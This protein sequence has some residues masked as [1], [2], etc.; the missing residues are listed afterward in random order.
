MRC[1]DSGLKPYE[2]E[3][4]R[5]HS[6]LWPIEHDPS[7]VELLRDCLDPY[8][9]NRW[10]RHDIFLLHCRSCGALF[11]HEP[12][13]YFKPKISPAPWLMDNDETLEQY[14]SRM[15]EVRAHRDD[16]F[17]R[18]IERPLVFRKYLDEERS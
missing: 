5:L 15:E 7:L 11:I 6:R 12:G 18:G 13:I 3:N 16:W 17:L 8:T 14:E 4:H 10:E 2:W 1:M 9:R